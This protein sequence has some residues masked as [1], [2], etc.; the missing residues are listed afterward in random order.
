MWRV[1]RPV[2]RCYDSSEADL[3]SLLGRTGHPLAWSEAGKVRQ[4]DTGR[5][6]AAK[7]HP[8][9]VGGDVYGSR[10]GSRYQ[11][12][13]D[14]LRPGIE[15]MPSPLRTG[16]SAKWESAGPP[17]EPA[18]NNKRDRLCQPLVN[19]P[20]IAPRVGAKPPAVFVRGRR[21]DVLIG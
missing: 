18:A 7:E 17:S 21:G 15:V 10:A 13:D 12:K 1:G 20:Q 6:R 14:L 19:E 3:V 4:K 9:Q 2:A 5:H 11:G 16:I 8:V